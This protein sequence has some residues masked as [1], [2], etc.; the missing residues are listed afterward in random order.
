MKMFEQFIG[1]IQFN[2]GDIVK[3]LPILAN[4]IK[5]R[6]WPDDMYRL[7]GN[8]YVVIGVYSNN[9]MKSKLENGAYIKDEK[10][11]MWYVPE[12][13]MKLIGIEEDEPDDNEWWLSEQNNVIGQ[14]A[15][16]YSNWHT[17][18]VG[19]VVKF[20]KEHYK[21]FGPGSWASTFDEQYKEKRLGIIVGYVGD[22]ARIEWMNSD[23]QPT[24]HKEKYLELAKR[25]MN[26]EEDP[27]DEPDDNEW[28]LSE[29]NKEKDSE[30]IYFKINNRKEMLSFFK[31]LELLG[32]IWSGT[33]QKPTEH[34]TYVP[35]ILKVNFYEQLLFGTSGESE[36]DLEE[37]CFNAKDFEYCE[38]FQKRIE[39]IKLKKTKEWEKNKEID[40]FGEEEW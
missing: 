8:V 11:M 4:T 32:I 33:G 26:L 23:D 9:A 13:C 39:E 19:D 14:Y 36:I 10:D 31:K 18:K 30:W 5:D 17:F 1:E 24:Y 2:K 40:P 20:N 28:W 7:I 25:K 35:I 15:N 38:D 37:K 12:D 22:E 21:D 27:F 3:I 34:L 6:Y 16:R 29:Q